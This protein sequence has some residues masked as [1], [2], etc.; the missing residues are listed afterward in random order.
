MKRSWAETSASRNWAQPITVSLKIMARRNVFQVV[1]HVI[2]L[3]L[4]GRRNGG[5][6]ERQF[7]NGCKCG[8]DEFRRIKRQFE[9]QQG[10]NR[11]GPGDAASS[12][13]SSFGGRRQDGR[14]SGSP[15]IGPG[16]RRER[17][18]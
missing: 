5:G 11:Q 14:R 16:D 9:C 15:V 8:G 4:G 2:F 17:Q 6:P 18:R 13:E 12:P 7:P 3:G 1:F 10:S